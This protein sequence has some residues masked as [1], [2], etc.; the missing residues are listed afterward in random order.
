MRFFVTWVNRVNQVV[1]VTAA[2]MVVVAVAITCQMIFIR[3]VL[4]GSTAWQTETVIYLI[5]GATMLGMGYVQRLK[6]HVN[7][8]L[9]AVM[10]PPSLRKGLL[11]VAAL[12]SIVV[13]SIMAFYGYEMAHIA[14]AKNWTSDTVNAV[15]LWI[16]YSVMPIG[17]GLFALQLVA[18]LIDTVDTPA[19]A[20]ELAGGGH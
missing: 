13:V 10:L 1:G 18:D 8:D 12:A 4:N 3:Y 5:L 7:V 19:E 15:P 17:F 11:I 2:M 20:I 6:G 9:V 14:W 16:P